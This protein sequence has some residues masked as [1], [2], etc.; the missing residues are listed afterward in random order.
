MRSKSGLVD[1]SKFLDGK[2]AGGIVEIEHLDVIES[3]GGEY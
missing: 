3:N 2:E 1:G